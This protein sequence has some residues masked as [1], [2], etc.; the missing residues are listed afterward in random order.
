[1]QDTLF[2]WD[3]LLT[4]GGASLL[5]FFVVQYTKV[6]VDRWFK[7]M[8]TD[9]YAVLIAWIVLTLAQLAVGASWSDWRLYMLALAN[10]F[11]VAAAAGQMQNK[12]LKPP[13]SKS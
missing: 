2:T 12:A 1:M 9:I 4:M 13:G 5:T 11:L 6:L 8:P 10:A 7:G 3:A